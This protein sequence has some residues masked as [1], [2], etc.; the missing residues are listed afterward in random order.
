MEREKTNLAEAKDL[1]V[2]ELIK[3]FPDLNL[4]DWKEIPLGLSVFGVGNSEAGKDV[5]P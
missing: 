3:L 2:L 5:S 4:N 1:L